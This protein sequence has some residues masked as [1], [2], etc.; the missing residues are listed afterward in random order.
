MAEQCRGA[1]QGSGAAVHLDDIV[2]SPYAAL[3]FILRHCEVIRGHVPI[4]SGFRIKS[5]PSTPHSSGFARLASG[6]FYFVVSIMTYYENSIFMLRGAPRGM[7]VFYEFIDLE[8]QLCGGPSRTVFP[9]PARRLVRRCFDAREE[10]EQ[11]SQFAIT[12]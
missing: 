1:V 5:P 12:D 7:R 9:P 4:P 8:G 3:R 2:K 11:G 6:S 10:G